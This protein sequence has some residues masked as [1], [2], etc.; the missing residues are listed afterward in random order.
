[1][2]NGYGS[3]RCL[4]PSRSL[5]GGIFAGTLI[6]SALLS[7][8]IA[9]ATEFDTDDDGLTNARE[10]QFGTKPDVADT[11]ADGLGDAFEV[12]SR[13]SDGTKA[14]TDGDGDDDLQE[15]S[16][17]TDPRN[18]GC[19]SGPG[20]VCG[21]LVPPPPDPP[22]VAPPPTNAI[23]VNFENRLSGVRVNVNSSAP[24]K[25]NCTYDAT[26]PDT[27]IPPFHKNFTIEPNGGA[28]FDIPAL[29]LGVE[30]NTVTVC[31]GNVNGADVELGRKELTKQF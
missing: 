31:R 15:F 21:A 28:S 9:F 16:L 3:Y 20:S 11:D 18:P 22:E 7:P 23:S 27:L 19:F 8:A 30:Y 29:Q 10:A 5:I 14:D 13:F 12:N 6:S 24:V 25:A 26:A 2:T 4:S 1:M 17:G